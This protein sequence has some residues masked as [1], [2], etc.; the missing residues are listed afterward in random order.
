MFLSCSGPTFGGSKGGENLCFF[1]RCR[2]WFRYVNMQCCE[3]LGGPGIV[4]NEVEKVVEINGKR[5]GK[6]STKSQPK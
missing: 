5:E 3:T 2:K 4:T 6:K 1:E